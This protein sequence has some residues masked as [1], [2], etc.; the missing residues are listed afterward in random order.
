M[1]YAREIELEAALQ[2][3]AKVAEESL[4]FRREFRA[5]IANAFYVLNKSQE[6]KNENQPV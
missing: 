1:N 3:L 4:D 6:V 5:A 2:V